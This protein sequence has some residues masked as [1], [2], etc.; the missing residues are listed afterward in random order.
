MT[1]MK[2]MFNP[3]AVQ[4]IRLSAFLVMCAL[5]LVLYLFQTVRGRKVDS[6]LDRLIVE[7][8]ML[9][10]SINQSYYKIEQLKQPSRI[11][12]LAKKRLGMVEKKG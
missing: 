6:D 8:K 5:F 1:E 10:N 2:K 7:K 3:V 11:I 9:Y 12:P 4:L